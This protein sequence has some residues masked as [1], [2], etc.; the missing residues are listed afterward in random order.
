MLLF[1]YLT[2]VLEAGEKYSQG[3][4]SLPMLHQLELKTEYSQSARDLV[5]VLSI[6]LGAVNSIMLI[7][8][9]E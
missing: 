3:I 5:V 7:S 2:F 6:M 1:S 4:K 8:R 9:T